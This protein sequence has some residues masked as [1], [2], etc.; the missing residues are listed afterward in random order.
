MGENRSK[1]GID[2]KRVCVRRDGS[3]WVRLDKQ[4]EPVRDSI[5]NR[6]RV[7][8]TRP[9]VAGRALLLI[10]VAV[11]VIPFFSA[12]AVVIAQ[13]L[14]SSNAPSP[15]TELALDPIWDAEGNQAGALFGISVSSAG[16]V[17]NDGYV[18]ILV[19]A[20]NY[21]NDQPEE[22]AAFLYLGSPSGFPTSPSWTAEG[23]QPYAHFG[24]SVSSVG[25][26]NGDGWDDVI[27]GAPD[28][29]NGQTDEGCAF[30]YL[31][32]P[33]G[34][35][36]S[37]SLTVELNQSYAHFGYSVSGAGNVN[38]YPPP[39]PD[40]GFDDVIVGAPHFRISPTEERGCAVVY[41]GSPSGLDFAHLVAVI[42][43]QAGA[44]FGYCVSSAGDVNND[45]R[46]DVIVGAPYYDNGQIDE[47]LAFVYFGSPVGLDPS[48]WWTYESNVSDA[49]FGA[50]VSSAGDVSNDGCDDVIIGS[51]D[52]ANGQIQEG[53]AFIYLGSTSSPPPTSPS[54]TAEGNSA[55]GRFGMSVAHAG[56]TN[57]DGYN[58][59]AIGAPGYGAT[60]AGGVFLYHGS[61]S[62]PSLLPSWSAESDQAL[63]QFGYSVS[64]AGDVNNDGYDDVIVGSPYY[65]NGETDEGRAFL[66]TGIQ[67]PEFQVVLV[68]VIGVVVTVIALRRAKS[69]K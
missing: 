60:N 12:L 56:D 10:S 11:A 68:P 37:P 54:W 36:S 15:I 20:C 63:S 39:L 50:S 21:S 8:K 51:P 23:D 59:V 69:Q 55:Y 1:I 35:P 13:G 5:S 2:S 44:D 17:N 19:G 24:F 62:G 65:D 58:D 14:S 3:S 49:H 66:Y 57:L 52:Y 47:G 61:P 67:I 40:E 4:Q 18:D 53:A 48:T 29:D 27:I 28:Y 26:V 33:T 30:L 31:G 43:V 45:S 46:D 16:D 22:G 38:N 42:G 25:N 6:M 41:P 34:L 64:S 7:R 32:S 9:A